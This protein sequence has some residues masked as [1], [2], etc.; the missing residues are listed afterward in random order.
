M[1]Q[2]ILIDLLNLLLQKLPNEK[3]LLLYVVHGFLHLAGYDDH[4]LKDL[5]QMRLKE[6][7]LME[8]TKQKQKKNKFRPPKIFFFFSFFFSI[9]V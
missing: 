3:E 7:Q 8:Q 9:F 4:S 1:P 5:K 2:L 6:K